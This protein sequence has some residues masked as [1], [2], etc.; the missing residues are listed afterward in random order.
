MEPNEL[1]QIIIVTVVVA[2]ISTVVGLILRK[3][4]RLLVFLIP[5]FFISVGLYYLLEIYFGDPGWGGIVMVFLMINS[6][7]I[8]IISLFVGIILFIRSAPPK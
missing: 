2:V 3:I 5:A 7:I 6:F 4:H 1:F 8:G